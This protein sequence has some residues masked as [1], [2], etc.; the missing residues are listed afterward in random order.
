MALRAL[1]ALAFAG[2]AALAML[3][4]C[5]PLQ[6]AL[7]FHPQ[8]PTLSVPAPP[9]GWRAEPIALDRGDGVTVRGWLVLP[10]AA[11]A[12]AV[13]YVGGNAEE[14]S[15]LVAHADRFG[16]RAVALVNYRGFGESGGKPAEEALVGDA[17]ALFDALSARP[18][19]RGGIAAMGRSLGT[20]IA[21]RLAAQRPVDRLVLVSPY[22]SIEA[23]G[24]HYFPSALVRAVIAD[25]YDAK[26]HAPA[27]RIPMLAVVAGSDEVIPVERSRSL[28]DAW[29]GPKR[30]VE[31]PHAG[32]NDLQEHA[33]FWREIGAFLAGP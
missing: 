11:P 17:A 32:H 25:R 22:D 3:T 27:L 2:V 5:R 33:P 4:G 19:V 13:V 24:A 1:R 7:L 21:V 9:A 31:V 30:W 26:S 16:G 6:N 23:V 12:R 14:V 20:G 15:W 18:D 28:H 10:P 8:P 29:G